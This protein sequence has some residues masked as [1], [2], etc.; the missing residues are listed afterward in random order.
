[1]AKLEGVAL[2]VRIDAHLGRSEERRRP[3]SVPEMKK[4]R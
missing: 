3:L 1:M 2:V 4:G